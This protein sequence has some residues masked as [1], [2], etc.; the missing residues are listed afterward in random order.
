MEL[1]PQGKQILGRRIE[2]TRTRS[3]LH[4]PSSQLQGITKPVLIDSVGDEVSKYHPGQIVIAHHLNFF[5]LRDG[6]TRA[7]FEEK[8]VMMVIEGVPED[9]VEIEGD[10]RKPDPTVAHHEISGEAV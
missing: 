7:I 6:F 3:G 10:E 2:V 4:L 5:A 8:E 1:I 9:Q